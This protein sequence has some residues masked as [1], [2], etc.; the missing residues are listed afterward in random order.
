MKWI[1]QHENFQDV[2]KALAQ[3]K[4]VFVE[5]FPIVV[6]ED[7]STVIS[8]VDRLLETNQARFDK[9]KH[10]I[11]FLSTMYEPKSIS[12]KLLEF[13]K[14]DFKSFI[15]ELKKQKVKLTPKQ[16]MDLMPLF[17]EKS[18]ELSNLSQEINKLD[19]QLDEVVYKLYGLNEEEIKIVESGVK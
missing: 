17:Q 13:Y 7:Q 8:L 11:E 3:V 4:K 1:Y 2:G 10:F 14:M 12:E 19:A 9:S 6:A 15:N 18:L 5:R 16:E